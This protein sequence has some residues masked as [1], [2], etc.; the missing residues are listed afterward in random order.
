[1]PLDYFKYPKRWRAE[2]RPRI[3]ARDGHVCRCCK[4]KNHRVGY[5]DAGGHFH[6]LAAGAPVPAG[7]KRLKILLNVVHLDHS[8]VDHSDDN[9]A[10]MCQQC[11]VRYDKPITAVQ[12]ATTTKYPGAAKVL[13]LFLPEPVPTK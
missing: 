5:R 7:F 3:L 9:L 10:L 2:V 6:E 4:V 12:A 1:M 8:L 11:H 13:D